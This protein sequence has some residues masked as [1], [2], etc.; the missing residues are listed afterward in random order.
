MICKTLQVFVNTLTPD[1]KFSLL[2][3]E[4][5]VQPI[6][7]ILSEKKKPV[8]DFFFAFSKS[9]LNFEYFPKR[10]TRIADVFLQLHTPKNVARYRSKKSRFRGPF[11]TQD[12]KRVETLLQSERQE[13]YHI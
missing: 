2:N 3:R 4:N 9:T 8:L 12:G 7:M 11:V 1:D 5:L 10:M 13:R 6:H